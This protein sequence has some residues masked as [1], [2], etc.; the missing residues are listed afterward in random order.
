VAYQLTADRWPVEAV[1][2]LEYLGW[3]NFLLAAFNLLLA[4]PLDGGRMLRAA[5]WAGKRDLRRATR[6]AGA[7]G[8]AFGL[9]LIAPGVLQFV[10][11]NFV[12]G[13]WWIL[14]GF[15]LRRLSRLAYGQIL[16]KSAL[17][18]EAVSRFMR[19]DAVAATPDLTIEEL[20]T[21][22]MDGGG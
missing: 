10:A 13:V 9:A 14:L 5:L 12:T 20:F 2:V 17:R 21:Q 15:F 18:G 11:G 16:L 4:F 3:V 8:A 7:I 6:A 22:Y 19:T 1:G